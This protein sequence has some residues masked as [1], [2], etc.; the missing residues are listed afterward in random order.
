[1]A[2]VQIHESSAPQHSASDI[3]IT[4]IKEEV[5]ALQVHV[6]KMDKPWYQDG[7]SIVA[8]LALVFS[9]AT[10]YLAFDRESRLDQQAD[11]TELRTLI[12]RLGAL[13]RENFELLQ[14]YVNN[15][16]YVQLS[17]MLNGEALI[18]TNQAIDIMQRIPE[19]VSASE[20]LALAASLIQTG[21]T[22]EAQEQTRLAALDPRAS[23]LD[24]VVAYRNL[25]V[26]AF[27]SGRVAQG[28]S[29]FREALNVFAARS[30]STS[31]QFEL[32]TN[33]ITEM[34]WSQQEAI[35]Q[36]CSEAGDHL[37]RAEQLLNQNPGLFDPSFPQQIQWTRGMIEQC[38]QGLPITLPSTAPSTVTPAPPMPN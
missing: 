14:K 25:G 30:D 11:R 26:H 34:Y 16:L 6:M 19:L 27:A 31:P 33:M 29:H 37:D 7:S 35:A 18:L 4:K 12:Q 3:S 22:N 36:R 21:R 9:L 24:L 2:M 38:E 28:R 13:P 10:T 1:M 20:R 17:G 32:Y 8:I 23:A 5:D 15:P